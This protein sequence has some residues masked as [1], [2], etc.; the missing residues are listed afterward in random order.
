MS[1]KTTTIGAFPKPDYVTLPDWFDN[2]DK[3]DP[4]AGWAEAMAAMGDDADDIVA[5]GIRDAVAAQTDA[6]IDIPT[7]G[8]I[9]RENYI[10]YHCRHLS[11]IDF[12][13]LTDKPVRGGNYVAA[14]PTIRDDIR[15]GEPF[16][17]RDYEIAQRATD[18]PVKITL[19]GPM[20]LGDTVADAYYQDPVARGEAV[21]DALNVEIK[22]L[23]AAGCRYIQI[24]EPVF[25]RQ[26]DR[27]I[28]YG[29][30][31]VERAFKD[32]PTTATRVMHMCCGYPDRLDNPDYPKADAQAYV[33]LAGVVNASSV[34]QV[35]IEDAHRHND[36][37]L[38]RQFTDTTVI[39]GVV[40]VAKSRV[41]P[42]D[43]IVA[44]LTG[45][46]DHIDAER[47]VAAPDCG[48]GLLGWELAVSKLQNLVK[49]ANS[50]TI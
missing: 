7:D 40:T 12:G 49:A 16:L 38:L 19:P 36:L 4:T 32:C 26:P 13:G 28:D 5:R 45:A 22:A 44:R 30:S 24:D 39:L 37:E 47:L 21:A 8:E 34:Q 10:H 42:V 33:E 18:R 46:L 31:H 9:R 35:S 25:A 41:E 3:A 1:L 50:V 48:L 15:A 6:G 27:A 14:L 23:A 11:G 43:E 2:P 20:T 29:M 17:V